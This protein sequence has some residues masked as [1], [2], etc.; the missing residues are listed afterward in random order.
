[1]CNAMK[2]R[3]VRHSAANREAGYTLIEM[4]I[5]ITVVGLIL[6]SFISAYSI[7]QKTKA[8]QTTENN[9]SLLTAALGN[10]LVQYGR[11]PCPARLDLPRGDA[12]YGLETE[13][14]PAVTAPP[15]PLPA[16]P[17]PW[18]AGAYSNGLYFENGVS[19]VDVNPSPANTCLA[20]GPTVTG[21]CQIPRIR[22]GGIPFRSLG[23]PEEQSQDGWGNRFQYAVTE[24]LAVTTSYVRRSG[25]IVVYDRNQAAGGAI[26]LTRTDNRAH[27]VLFSSGIDRAGAFSSTGQQMMPCLAAG[28]DRENCN[29]SAAN[30]L[31]YYASG[32]LA[33]AMGAQH[34]DDYVQFFSSVETP[35]WRVADDGG[36][37]IRDLI[38]A[39]AGGQIGIGLDVPAVNATVDVAGEVRANDSNSLA[40]E[41]CDPSRSQCIPVSKFGSETDD[42]KCPANTYA[43][44]FGLRSNPSGNPTTDAGAKYIKCVPFSPTTCPPGEIMTGVEITVDYPKGKPKCTA[45]VTCPALTATVCSS[46]PAVT[47]YTIPADVQ[48]ATWA[49][50]VVGSSWQRNYV[51]NTVSGVTQWRTASTSGNCVCNA[52][53]EY[54]DQSCNA[55]KG[56]GNWTGVVTR[57]NWNYCPANTGGSVITANNCVCAPLTETRTVG[58]PIAGYTG[59]VTQQRQWICDSATAGHYTSWSNVSST[60]A[61]APNTQNQTLSCGTGYTGSIMQHRDFNCGSGSW[62]G[63]VTDSNTCTCA[64]GQTENRSLGCTYP[65][66]GSIDQTRTFNCATSSWGAW[67]TVANSCTCAGA[68]ENRTV[69]CTGAHITGTRLERRTYDCPTST[70]G[71][72]TEIS[73]TCSCVA[74]VEF[75]TVACTAPLLGNITEQRTYNCGTASWGPWVEAANNCGTVAYSWVS[76]TAATGPFG[77]PLAVQQGSS[78]SS[79]GANSSCSSPAGGGQY[80]HYATCQCE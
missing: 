40:S 37:H 46:T 23:L 8:Q 16:Y 72:W 41:V 33:P 58:C 28:Y 61:C 21:S 14:N 20:A 2:L 70:W 35:L 10:F 52:L 24:N 73:N 54:V 7:Y 13:C 45:V 67:T 4:A 80:W 47:T 50:P 25:G 63:W 22:R 77:A 38:D 15:A 79:V 29:T 3:D 53:D 5:V 71:S 44:A 36:F 51:C 78:C 32:P 64:P 26:E 62:G 48:G 69:A 66:T 30:A 68:T 1:M 56:T 19:H 39:E 11:Y 57:H 60:C 42:F 59:S 76:K 17:S 49:S 18:T 6:G 9:A 27:Y 65:Q 43:R 12:R 75:R 34:F 31:A 55:Y 74:D